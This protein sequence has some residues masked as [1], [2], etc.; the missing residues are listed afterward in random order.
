MLSV[1]LFAVSQLHIYL[2]KFTVYKGFQRFN[3]FVGIKDICIISKEVEIEF[4]RG[5]LYVVCV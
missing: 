4:V 1:N 3:I 2:T 5:V